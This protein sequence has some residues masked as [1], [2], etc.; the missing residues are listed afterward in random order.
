MKH[1]QYQGAIAKAGAV[2]ADTLAAVTAGMNAAVSVPVDLFDDGSGRSGASSRKKDMEERLVRREMGH[3][4]FAVESHPEMVL[5]SP[6]GSSTLVTGS[7]DGFVEVWEIEHCKLRKD[8]EYQAKDE[9]MMHTYENNGVVV[10]AAVLCG[11]FS[12]DGEHLAT[13][14]QDG[15]VKVWKLA[16]GACLRKIL[17]AHTAGITSISFN[18]DN[19]Q[20]MT[21]SFDQLARVHGLKSGKALKEFR[22]HTSFVN[23]GVI[24][25]DNLHVLTG[26]SDGTCRLWDYQTTE[27]LLTFRPGVGAGCA[28]TDAAVHTLL[29]LP[30]PSSAAATAAGAQDQLIVCTRHYQAHLITAQGRVLRTFS[31]GK[32]TNGC[33]TCATMSN[34]GR[35]LYCAGEDGVVYMF[36]VLSGELENIL[37]AIVTSP[38]TEASSA[39][40]AAPMKQNA[41][42]HTILVNRAKPPQEIIGIAHHA[43]RNVV[44]TITDDGK[45]TLW[46]P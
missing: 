22:G 30:A 41:N 4:A 16:T 42:A 10:A 27:C 9:L 8:L 14:S 15:Q 11:A 45:L 39:A 23:C 2:G 34:N 43:Q 35:W 37:E 26:S 33:F 25:S 20:L 6:E 24:T 5:F 28:V 36:D 12:Q 44:A 1:Q 3:I 40:G 29:P 21:T 7:V 32:Q 17:H 46:K 18:K 13:G 38:A 31:S 19:S